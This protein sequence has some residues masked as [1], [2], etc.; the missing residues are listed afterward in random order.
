[1]QPKKDIGQFLTKLSVSL[2]II[3]SIVVGCGCNAWSVENEAIKSN[4]KIYVLV[5]FLYDLNKNYHV[6]RA[7]T[8]NTAENCQVQG[9]NAVKAI[10]RGK[11]QNQSFMCLEADLPF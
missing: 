6:I 9:N 10:N 1:M 2:G 3:I 7:A 5:L 11:V 8:Y 4:T